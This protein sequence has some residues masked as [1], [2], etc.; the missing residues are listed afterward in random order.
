[1]SDSVFQTEHVKA[2]D[3]LRGYAAVAVTFYHAILQLQP[4]LVESVVSPAISDIAR[5]DWLAKVMLIVFDGR[6]AVLLFY[7][8]SGC[9]LCH[10]LLKSPLA[11]RALSMFVVRRALRLF[12]ALFLCLFVM[13]TLSIAHSALSVAGFPNVTVIAALKN[14]VLFDTGVHGPSTSIQVEAMATPFVLLFF[15]L[16]RSFAMPAALLMLGVAAIVLEKPALALNLPNLSGALLFFVVGMFVALPE[17]KALF[18]RST[19]WQLTMVL[20]AAVVIRHFLDI[21][22]ASAFVAQAILF[23]ALVGFVRWSSANTRMHEF[24]E[25]RVSQLL[26]RVSYSYYLLN[27]AVLWLLWFSPA[28]RVLQTWP[29]PLVGGLVVGTIATGLTVP[30]AYL[31]HRYCELPFIELGKRI[32]RGQSL[33]RQHAA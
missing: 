29:N 25:N 27:V 23:G 9:V 33:R 26:G 30:L 7:T 12:P 10:S 17:C 11:A 8:L 28:F 16:Y 19:G 20:I 21:A 32:T 3:G 2:L 18:A 13:W 15:L 22:S 6:A 5:A 31:S 1:M 14:A 24:L 4:T